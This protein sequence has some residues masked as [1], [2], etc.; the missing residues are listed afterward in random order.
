MLE[1]NAS[2]FADYFSPLFESLAKQVI[3]RGSHFDRHGKVFKGHDKE[4]KEIDDQIIVIRNNIYQKYSEWFQEEKNRLEKPILPKDILVESSFDVV[5]DAIHFDKKKGIHVRVPVGQIY[6]VGSSSEPIDLHGF[7]EIYLAGEVIDKKD[8]EDS[9]IIALSEYPGQF[10]ISVKHLLPGISVTK[11][12]Y[13]NADFIIPTR[14]SDPVLT[15]KRMGNKW[16]TE[17]GRKSINKVIGDQLESQISQIF[18]DGK[19]HLWIDDTQNVLDFLFT[20]IEKNLKEW[21][22]STNI[23]SISLLRIYPKNLYSIALEMGSVEQLIFNLSGEMELSKIQSRTGLNEEQLLKIKN[24]KHQKQEPG[25]LLFST[26]QSM[27]QVKRGDLIN[28]LGEIKKT[29]LADFV[30]SLYSNPSSEVDIRFSEQV[31]LHAIKN[32][33]LCS[34]ESLEIESNWVSFYSILQSELNLLQR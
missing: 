16:L 29:N 8:S 9:W 10:R 6:V 20:S 22:L 12:D 25:M 7:P 30:L 13:A 18:I 4:V 14:I 31:L 21:G 1:K 34:G 19:L 2:S 26:I 24:I 32:P 27:D 23:D 33:V 11:E 5:L 15:V 17:E 28:W 3:N